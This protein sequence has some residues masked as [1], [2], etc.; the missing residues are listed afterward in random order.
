MNRRFLIA[1]IV[2]FIAWMLGDFVV[3]G[4]LLGNDY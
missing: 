2:V 3:H 4:A 1:W